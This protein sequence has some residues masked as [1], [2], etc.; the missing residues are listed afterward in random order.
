MKLTRAR[1][2]NFK[3]LQSVNI[4]FEP[5]YHP[6]VFPLGGL[7][8][9]GKST[10]LQL[11]YA[12]LGMD[13][14]CINDTFVIEDS[15]VRLT[16]LE[17]SKTNDGIFAVI[18][19]IVE[20]DQQIELTYCYGAIINTELPVSTDNKVYTG[21]FP[22]MYPETKEYEPM[23]VHIRADT[24][25]GRPLYE[26]LAHIKNSIVLIAPEDEVVL[27]DT[28]SFSTYYQNYHNYCF[29]GNNNNVS[30]DIS[31]SLQNKHLAATLTAAAQT[32]GSNGLRCHKAFSAGELKLISLYLALVRT[33]EE[34]AV[35]LIDDIESTLHPDWQRRVVD[36]LL[37]WKPGGQFILATHS[38]ELC[39]G[40]TPAHVKE[41]PSC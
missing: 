31:I 2:S 30:R 14:D 5:E 7:N 22:I 23:F 36:L 35:F 27:F 17:N 15:G 29:Y 25:S 21:S 16:L 24:G 12:L 40:I 41:L 8:G 13:F 32:I 18:N 4:E 38:Y 1:I 20:D 39:H 33:A 11:I 28:K 26:Q 9:C 37:A 3:A 19:L 6:Q 10:F 34:Q